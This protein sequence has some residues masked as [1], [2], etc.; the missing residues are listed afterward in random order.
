M[1]DWIKGLLSSAYLTLLVVGIFI[2][3]WFKD[4]CTKQDVQVNNRVKQKGKDNKLDIKDVKQTILKKRKRKK[5]L[6]HVFRGK[7]NKKNRR[8]KS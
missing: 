5:F 6:K 1:K 8:L 2:G 4:N 3:Y 7:R